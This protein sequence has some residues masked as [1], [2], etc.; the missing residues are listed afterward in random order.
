MV[1]G[2]TK[3][4]RLKAHGVDQRSKSSRTNSIPPHSKRLGDW[5][6]RAWQFVEAFSRGVAFDPSRHPCVFRP[7]SPPSLLCRKR[8]E[9][10]FAHAAQTRIG[11]DLGDGDPLVPQKLKAIRG[12]IGPEISWTPIKKHNVRAFQLSMFFP[13]FKPTT[14]CHSFAFE[15][16][17]LK[18][19][20]IRRDVPLLRI[21]ENGHSFDASRSNRIGSIRSDGYY[22][23]ILTLYRYKNGVFPSV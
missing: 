8:P 3:R 9:V 15:G 16:A 4:L 18:F 7:H 11:V 13:H 10:I 5:G 21:R 19:C 14:D 2:V 1:C 6:C 17:I 12:A 20:R 22:K 23:P